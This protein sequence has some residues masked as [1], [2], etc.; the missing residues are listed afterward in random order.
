MIEFSDKI[1]LDRKLTEALELIEKIKNESIQ[2]KVKALLVL[3]FSG[4]NMKYDDQD[5]LKQILE[6]ESDDL[7]N[8]SHQAEN[9]SS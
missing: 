5:I 8:I 7:E 9:Y 3:N 4:L 6:S 2:S 1:R